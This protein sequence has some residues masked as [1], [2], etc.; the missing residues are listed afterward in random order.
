MGKFVKIPIENRFWTKVEVRGE[1]ECWPWI[2]GMRNSDNYGCV[3][4]EDRVEAAHRVAW[5]LSRGPI[6]DGL[7]VLHSCDNPRCVNP[8]HLF[9]G[10]NND[11]VQDKVRKGRSYRAC[12]EQSGTHKLTNDAVREIRRKYAQGEATH[13]QLAREFGVVEGTIGFVLREETWKGIKE[14]PVAY[15]VDRGEL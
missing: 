15:I 5:R 2:A 3:R 1:D 4:Y 10:T 12:G 6:P 7:Q 14:E 8:K 13:K 9:L 11:N